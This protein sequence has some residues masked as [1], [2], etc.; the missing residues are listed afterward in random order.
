VR[1]P[2]SNVISQLCLTLKSVATLFAVF[3]CCRAGRNESDGFGRDFVAGKKPLR[4]Y[5]LKIT[6]GEYLDTL[7]RFHLKDVRAL[8]GGDDFCWQQ[9]LCASL[10]TR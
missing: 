1:V 8:Y 6:A 3:V 4:I 2:P 5:A 9:V 7:K 10:D